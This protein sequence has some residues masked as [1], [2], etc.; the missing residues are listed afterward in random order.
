M[1]ATPL[2]LNRTY[3]LKHT[4]Q[5]VKACVREVRYRLDVNTLEKR[6][7][8]ELRLNDIGAVVS[9]APSHFYRSLS[10]KPC[11]GQRNPGRPADERNRSGMY[12]YRTASGW[13]GAASGCAGRGFR[14]AV[15]FLA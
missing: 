11:H 15:P 4:T 10:S 12:V 7:D 1:S 5:Q 8:A 2:N 3:L 9:N 6:P 13:R 14:A